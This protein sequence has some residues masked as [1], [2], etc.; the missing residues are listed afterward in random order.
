MK[1]GKEHRC[2]KS[3]AHHFRESKL[4]KLTPGFAE[5]SA[6]P[7]QPLPILSGYFPSPSTLQIL[8][9]QNFR[10][11]PMVIDAAE[12]IVKKRSISDK[13]GLA[14]HT[15]MIGLN[16]PV[17]MRRRDDRRLVDLVNKR[18]EAGKRSWC[19]CDPEAPWMKYRRS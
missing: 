2:E 14:G 9:Q 16:V 1:K 10:S 5:Y 6:S 13:H 17:Q 8:M 7:A 3:S 12:S 15:D 4:C 11:Q 18:Y 19:C